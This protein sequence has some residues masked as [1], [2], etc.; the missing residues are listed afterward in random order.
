MM[1]GLTTA[2]TA[3]ALA[4]VTIGYNMVLPDGTRMMDETILNGTVLVILVTCAI[5]P[6]CT[7]EAAAKIKVRMMQKTRIA[8]AKNAA[9]F[10]PSSLWPT[11]SQPHRL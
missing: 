10:P 3:V 5:A 6:I 7:S 8:P 4:V 1:F 9:A 11:L 2:H